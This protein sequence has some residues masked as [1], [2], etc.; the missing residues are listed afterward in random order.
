MFKQD[1]VER[2]DAEIA[3][4]GLVKFRSERGQLRWRLKCAG[5]GI[6]TEVHRPDLNRAE[7]L[8][9]HFTKKDWVLAK[10]TPPYHSTPCYRAAIATKKSE[11][12]MP[13]APERPPPAAILGPQPDPKVLRRLFTLLTQHFDEENGRYAQGWNDELI[14]KEANALLD[15]VVK[16]RRES[17][18]EL[19]EHPDL[20]KLREDIKTLHD[21]YALNATEVSQR[22]A[23]LTG[24][25]D[26]LSAG[27]KAAGK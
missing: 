20:V 1:A 15:F 4:F 21:D 22:L 26:A 11:N 9:S 19:A 5:C 6:T 7:E 14:A 24:R 12:A 10:D 13:K 23:D 25:L 8:I 17:F 18:S 27:L 16:Y 3:R 2:L